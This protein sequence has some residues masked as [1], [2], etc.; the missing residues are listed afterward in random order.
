M[1]RLMFLREWK[2]A[3]EGDYA[4]QRNVAFCF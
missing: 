3:H 1:D 4:P 2:A